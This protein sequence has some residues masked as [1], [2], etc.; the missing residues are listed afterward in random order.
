MQKMIAVDPETYEKIAALAETNGRTLGGQI[1]WL[2][3]HVELNPAPEGGTP[4]IVLNV[5]ARRAQSQEPE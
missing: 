5:A 3:K 1:K 4:V 2:V